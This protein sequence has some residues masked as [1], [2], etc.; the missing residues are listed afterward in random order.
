MSQVR[1]VPGESTALEEL[2]TEISGLSD[3]ERRRLLAALV[4]D[5]NAVATD[6]SPTAHRWFGRPPG[7]GGCTEIWEYLSELRE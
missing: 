1:G 3:D 2:K 6:P 7:G 4:T 5:T